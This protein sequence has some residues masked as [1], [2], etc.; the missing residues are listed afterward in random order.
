MVRKI[1]SPYKSGKLNI[2]FNGKGNQQIG[3]VVNLPLNSLF[4]PRLCPNGKP[5]H[6]SWKYCPW[7][8]TPLP[9]K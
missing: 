7:D 1:G 2:S 9:A 5:A 6:V 3:S 8:G 4:I